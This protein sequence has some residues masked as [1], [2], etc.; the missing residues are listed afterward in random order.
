MQT[1][2]NEAKFGCIHRSY[3]QF[4]WYNSHSPHKVRKGCQL[5]TDARNVDARKIL[6]NIFLTQPLGWTDDENEVLRG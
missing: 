6:G 1:Y 2:M 5:I 4:G 3:L